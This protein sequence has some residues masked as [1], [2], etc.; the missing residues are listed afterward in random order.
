MISLLR[1]RVPNRRALMN[2][3]DTN[4]LEAVYITP[5]SDELEAL[6]VFPLLDAAGKRI[7][8]MLKT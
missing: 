2:Y 8:S 3:A 7:L 5:H 1:H 4:W 6:D